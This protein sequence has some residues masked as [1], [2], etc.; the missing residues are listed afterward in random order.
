MT[1]DEVVNTLAF[2]CVKELSGLRHFPKSVI[3]DCIKS[4]GFQNDIGLTDEIVE[5]AESKISAA[6]GLLGY[7]KGNG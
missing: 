1:V 2:K 4:V 6:L 3:T 5:K 7:G